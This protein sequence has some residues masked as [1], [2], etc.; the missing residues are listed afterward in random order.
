[1]ATPSLSLIVAMASNGVIGRNNELPWHLPKDLRHFK[2]LTLDHPILMG[3]KT[4]ESI[5]RPL[6]RRRSLVLSRDVDLRLDGAEV[7][8]TIDDALAAVDAA[9]VFVIG[10]AA[11]FSAT[12]PRADDLYLTRVHAEP[13]G[14]VVWSG[15]DLADWR[16]LSAEDHPADEDHGHPFT[17]EHWQR[18]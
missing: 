2:R 9:K 18:S 16:R 10:G 15:F 6:P 13:Q 4:W 1:M 5:G 14:D 3:R 17:F 8:P 12:F 7:F 11:L